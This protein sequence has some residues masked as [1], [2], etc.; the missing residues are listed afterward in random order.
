MRWVIQPGYNH[1][2]RH[3]GIK[4]VKPHGRY[5]GTAIAICRQ[6]AN[7]YE[8]A[9][10]KHPRR[11]NQSTRYWHQPEEVWSS[12]PPEEPESSLALHLIKDAGLAAKE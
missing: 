8:K 4:F 5:G 7:L 3:S 6:R 2:H 10:Q 1:R 12:K 9:R 11:W